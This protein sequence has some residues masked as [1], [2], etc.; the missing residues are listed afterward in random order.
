MAQNHPA[1]RISD[2]RLAIAGYLYTR[3]LVRNGSTYWNCLK[4][5]DKQCSARAVTTTGPDNQIVVTKG[6]VQSAHRHPPN[7]EA[8]EAEAIKHRIK[9][10]AANNRRLKPSVI[11]RGI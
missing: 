2:H 8:A 1:T 4:L 5:R 3:A 9:Q 7:P 10:T 6:P 11:I